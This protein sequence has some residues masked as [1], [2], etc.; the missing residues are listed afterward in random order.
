MNI[1]NF[2]IF[3]PNKNELEK[4]IVENCEIVFES[5][6]ECGSGEMLVRFG[7]MKECG[8]K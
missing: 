7:T 3:S 4:R 1:Y 2:F 5:M 6:G 8:V